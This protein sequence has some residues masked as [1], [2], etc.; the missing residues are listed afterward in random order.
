MVKFVTELQ[1]DEI[2]ED[3]RPGRR[4][5]VTAVVAYVG[6]DGDT[7]M[8]LRKGDRLVC[9]ATEQLIGR[10]F[11]NAAVLQR[12]ARRGV[13]I[14]SVKGLH[15]KVVV[16]KGF[17][18]VGSANA[19][20]FGYLEAVVRLGPTD[21]KRVA[22]WADSLCIE[23]NLQSKDDLR[24][25]AAIP[26]TRKFTPPVPAKRRHLLHEVERLRLLRIYPEWSEEAEQA[27]DKERTDHTVASGRVRGMAGWRW[28]EWSGA[29]T[30]KANE[31]ILPVR[32]GRIGRPA[33]VERVSEYSKFSLVWYRE[34]STDSRP[35]QAALS[36]VVPTWGEWS[37]Q[38]DGTTLRLSRAVTDR[39]KK[40]FE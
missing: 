25:L 8:P 36:D 24:K 29:D 32:S 9:E 17:A 13:E 26:V 35:T 40:L 39:V 5:P 15:A 21:A 34:V 10:G 18:W 11:T 22:V 31:W 23:P 3:L 19:S 4:G 30:P 27:A 38:A 7:L 37:T 33:F 16:G 2:A 6:T 1:W 12:F 14:Y 20:N 28:I